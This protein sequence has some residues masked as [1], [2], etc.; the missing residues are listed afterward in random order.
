VV[1]WLGEL[2]KHYPGYEKIDINVIKNYDD[3]EHSFNY[4]DS[5]DNAIKIIKFLI[6]LYKNDINYKPLEQKTINNI[7][8]LFYPFKQFISL[9]KYLLSLHLIDDNYSKI[10]VNYDNGTHNNIIEGI[11]L[12]NKYDYPHINEIKTLINMTRFSYCNGFHFNFTIYKD[13]HHY[14]YLL[15]CGIRNIMYNKKI[16]L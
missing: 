4:K 12:C 9:S 2:Y 15:A 16:V 3:Y 5:R 10:N 8:R 6:S 13:N 1:K 7:F 11:V 14:K